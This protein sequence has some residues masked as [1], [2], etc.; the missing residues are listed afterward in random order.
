ML[1]YVHKAHKDIAPSILLS[2]WSHFTGAEHVARHFQCAIFPSRH[3]KFS[4]IHQ[5]NDQVYSL[6]LLWRVYIWLLPGTCHCWIVLSHL[7]DS[8]TY[9]VEL[10]DD[11]TL[12]SVNNRF[13]KRGLNCVDLF[14]FVWHKRRLMI[15]YSL[16]P[17]TLGYL[18]ACPA[19]HHATSNHN[20]IK[21]LSHRLILWANALLSLAVDVI[22][23]P[24]VEKT[25]PSQ[26]ESAIPPP[27]CWLRPVLCGAE[28]SER[29]LLHA[30]TGQG[31]LVPPSGWELNRQSAVMAVKLAAMNTTFPVC[32]FKIISHKRYFY[33]KDDIL[34]NILIQVIKCYFL[35][36]IE[37]AHAPLH[38]H[39]NKEISSI[40]STKA[41]YFR[42]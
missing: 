13:W 22:S 28:E 18:T 5:S 21:S 32:T 40:L 20:R 39:H 4:I 15:G 26:T 34:F 37:Y 19:G 9:C 27:E 8:A 16:D 36:T 29:F 30:V 35:Y 1:Q 14:Q 33:D 6:P 7:S 12:G 3:W 10:A 41:Q 11:K 38:F 24:H 25:L 23:Y 31:A 2:I 42:S 17:S